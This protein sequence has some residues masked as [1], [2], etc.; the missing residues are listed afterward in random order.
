MSAT[1]SGRPQLYLVR[2]GQTEWSLSGQHTG[3]T[4][5]PLTTHGEDQARLLAPRLGAVTFSHVLMSP[6]QRARSTCRLAGLDARAEITPDL[7]EW[8]YG[9]FEGL[10]SREI[11]KLHP[12]WNV[13][14]DGGPNGE[15]P[16]QIA[17]RADRVI[18]RLSTLAGNI[19][20]FSHGHFGRALGA[21]WIGLAL[22]DAQHFT[23]GEA[24]MSLLGY[25]PSHP[26][27]RV[28]SLWNLPPEM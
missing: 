18:K 5:L 19:A 1:A 11:H 6:L 17:D 15:T 20:L 24:S 8:D 14:R 9:D 3:L 13:Y 4:D 28:I 26:D 2:H 10:T 23:F 16:Q 12:D 25:N 21:R 22:S 27:V 7:A